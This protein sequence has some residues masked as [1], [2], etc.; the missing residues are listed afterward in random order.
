MSQSILNSLQNNSQKEIFEKELPSID[1]QTKFRQLELKLDNYIATNNNSTRARKFPDEYK[2]NVITGL[3]W[4][5]F[6]H[7]FK[8]YYPSPTI[9]DLSTSLIGTAQHMFSAL[10]LDQN[11]TVKDAIIRLEEMYQKKPELLR[12]EFSNYTR[13][14]KFSSIHELIFNFRLVQN[15]CNIQDTEA[16]QLLFQAL[17][18]NFIE[19]WTSLCIVDPNSKN[20]CGCWIDPEGEAT[21]MLEEYF[22]KNPNIDKTKPIIFKLALDAAGVANNN[23][24]LVTAT[25]EIIIDG[26]KSISQVKSL[27]NNVPFLVFHVKDNYEEFERK[28]RPIFSLLNQL[29]II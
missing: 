22:E 9:G 27:Y 2:F 6:Y 17:G 12:S 23:H 14:N 10:C 8:L 13:T 29:C 16:I 1:F 24:N 28:L 11:Y 3:E 19:Y 25:I 18:T 7:H 15:R 5:I 20:T 26:H 21:E 4:D